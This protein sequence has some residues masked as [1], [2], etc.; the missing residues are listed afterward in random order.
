VG[1]EDAAF[2]VVVQAVA[3]SRAA[4]GRVRITAA[5]LG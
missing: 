4:R 2:C 1:G 5:F 3:R